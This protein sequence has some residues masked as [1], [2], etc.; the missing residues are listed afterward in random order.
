M[1]F[2]IYLLLLIGTLFSCQKKEECKYA[3]PN[4]IFSDNIEALKRHK[5]RI[6][7]QVGIESLSFKDGT[8]LT[9]YQ[10]G[11]DYIKQ[12]Y[13]FELDTPL[14]STFQNDWIGLAVNQFEILGRL[15]SQ[16]YSFAFWAQAI[17]Q[18][19]PEMKLSQFKELQPGFYAK[20]D[21]IKGK[22]RSTLLVTLSEKP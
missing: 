3:T 6:R 22:N 5:F 20:V 2:Y 8:D 9:I 7:N 19:A 4:A 14:D 18:N 17:E 10:S 15:D 21:A 12:D 11:C 1:K 16:Y 13:E